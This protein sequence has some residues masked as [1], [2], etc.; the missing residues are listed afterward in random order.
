MT[1]SILIAIIKGQSRSQSLPGSY[2]REVLEL[3]CRG[4]LSQP[5]GK[6]TED[7]LTELFQ[8]PFNSSLTWGLCLLGNREQ[9]S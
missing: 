1:Y 9:K 5:E 8:M 7:F 6:G 2:L 4:L 3:G